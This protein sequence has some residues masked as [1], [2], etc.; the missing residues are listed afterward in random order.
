MNIIDGKQIRT[1]RHLSNLVPFMKLH[2]VILHLSLC[3]GNSYKILPVFMCGSRHFPYGGSCLFCAF[4]IA[5]ALRSLV[6]STFFHK[7]IHRFYNTIPHIITP[8]QQHC[9]KEINNAYM[10]FN[11][12]NLILLNTL[13]SNLGVTTEQL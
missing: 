1:L 9:G 2:R 7:L 4:V 3:Y 10:F 12:F 13:P 6:L 8:F 5:C 11:T